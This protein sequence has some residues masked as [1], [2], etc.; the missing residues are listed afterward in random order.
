VRG[1]S[2]HTCRLFAIRPETE[3]PSLLST[4][5]HFT[6]GAVEIRE[7]V[8]DS[9]KNELAMTLARD[10][11]HNERVFIV[12][13]PRW[14]PR[15]ALVGGDTAGMK[16]VAP[17]VIAIEGRFRDGQEIVVKFERKE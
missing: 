15:E 3:T 14:K 13:S 16:C 8:W 6:Q 4:S 5:M 12:F 2:P 17:E 9:Q 10:C 1:I 11:R 7:C